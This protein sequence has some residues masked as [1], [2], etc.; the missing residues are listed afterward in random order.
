MWCAVETDAV[1][2]KSAETYIVFGQQL[3]FGV[4]TG[5]RF[6]FFLV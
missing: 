1:V 2:E 4:V 6:A 3:L 5:L